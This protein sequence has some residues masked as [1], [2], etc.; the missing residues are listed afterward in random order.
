MILD[1]CDP[2]I[3][4][5]F[6]IAH[7]AP[8]IAG[9][10]GSG[11]RRARGPARTGRRRFDRGRGGAAGRAR[12]LVPRAA[13]HGRRARAARGGRLPRRVPALAPLSGASPR[14]RRPAGGAVR[15]RPPRRPGVAHRGTGGDGRGDPPGEPVRNRGR[16]RAGPGTRRIRCARRQRPGARHRRHGAPGV[17]RW[18]RRAHR[19]GRLRAGRRLSAPSSIAAREGVRARSGALGAASRERAVPVELPGSQSH[20]GGP[21]SD[22]ARRRGG[23][24]QRKPH[25]RGVRQGPRSLRRRGAGAHHV[26]HRAR[27]QQPAEGRGNA[28]QRDRG[29]AGRVVRGGRPVRAGDE[30]RARRAPGTG[31]P[32]RSWRPPRAATPCRRSRSAPAARSPRSAPR[33]GASKPTATSPA[34]SSAAGNG[35]RA[36]CRIHADSSATRAR[37]LLRGIS[38]RGGSR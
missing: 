17:P 6:L 36:E 31:A 15:R 28:D 25:H 11:D 4:R 13:R 32:R 2:C 24:S 21:R 12:S 33:S 20:H 3:R 26:Q 37:S 35:R 38:R 9:L 34:A 10:L 19:R 27:H 1:A 5:A 22:D 29:R 30:R 8:R 16:L 18:R 14:P 23:R 7:L